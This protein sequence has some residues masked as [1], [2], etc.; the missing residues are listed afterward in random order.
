[1]SIGFNGCSLDLQPDLWSVSIG[2]SVVSRARWSLANCERKESM[3]LG[4]GS[5]SMHRPVKDG[6][7]AEWSKAPASKAG[8]VL[9][10]REFKSRSS[11]KPNYFQSHY[12]LY[13]MERWPSG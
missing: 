9:S 3:T 6:E 4:L 13:N 7:M 1:M 5:V 11:A 10:P 12:I 2:V 8:R